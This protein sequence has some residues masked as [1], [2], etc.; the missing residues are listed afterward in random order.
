M[1]FTL[2]KLQDCRS[3]FP[4]TGLETKYLFLMINYNIIAPLS[5]SQ[6]FYNNTVMKSFSRMSVTWLVVLIRAP[7]KQRFTCIYLK[8]KKE[9]EEEV[10][11]PSLGCK[12]PNLYL[13]TIQLRISTSSVRKCEYHNR[14]DVENNAQLCVSWHLQ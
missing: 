1:S 3:S 11:P 4:G 13:R 8:K 12:C 6:I 7:F 5:S 9:E 14:N 2:R 10:F